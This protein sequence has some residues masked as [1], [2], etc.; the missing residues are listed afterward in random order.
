MDFIGLTLDSEHISGS[1]LLVV[2]CVPLALPVLPHLHEALAEPVAH[3]NTRMTAYERHSA[4]HLQS[5][6]IQELICCHQ[7][8]AECLPC[9]W[10]K[11]LRRSAA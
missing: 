8:A 3:I 9:L 5:I 10:P 2:D 6:D 7:R 1:T 4:H 11:L